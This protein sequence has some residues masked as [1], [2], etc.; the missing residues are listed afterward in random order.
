MPMAVMRLWRMVWQIPLRERIRVRRCHVLL[1]VW[2]RH[3]LLCESKI[4]ELLRCEKALR[5]QVAR[6]E[7][8]RKGQR[9]HSRRWLRGPR[10]LKIA[11]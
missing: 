6:R 5:H 10:G 2:W 9:S 11:L 8:R 7:V 4:A 1:C 3:V